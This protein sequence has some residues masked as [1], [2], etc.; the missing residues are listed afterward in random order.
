MKTRRRRLAFNIEQQD[1]DASI[2]TLVNQIMP[3]T[4]REIQLIWFSLNNYD[5][6][7]T[8]LLLIDSIHIHTNEKAPFAKSFGVPCRTAARER[9]QK[10]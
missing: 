3:S 5:I 7:Y 10:S 8:G 4:L 9:I 6:E 1:K 2:K